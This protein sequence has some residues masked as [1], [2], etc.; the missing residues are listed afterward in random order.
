M[1]VLRLLNRRLGGLPAVQVQQVQKLSIA[2]LEDL[3]EALL[4]FTETAD[5]EVYLEKFG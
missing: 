1:L 2:E 4:D 3:G 5:L